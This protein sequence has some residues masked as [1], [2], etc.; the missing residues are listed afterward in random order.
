[1]ENT[2]QDYVKE[3]M[4]YQNDSSFII[5]YYH[6]EG[7]SNCCDNQ[8][9]IRRVDFKSKRRNN[10]HETTTASSLS[11]ESKSSETLLTSNANKLVFFS[12]PCCLLFTY[13]SVI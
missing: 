12:L 3:I 13:I 1:M 8:K 11:K 2:T 4:V 10:K 6:T 5:Q 9:P 7:V